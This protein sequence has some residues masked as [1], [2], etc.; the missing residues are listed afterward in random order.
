LQCH[1][2]I[3][4]DA[5][6]CG[7]C[8]ARV[9]DNPI[10]TAPGE[11]KAARPAGERRQLTVVFCD[12][13]GSTPLSQQFDPEDWRDIV[14]QY[15]Q[16]VRAA[17]ERFSG[18]VAQEL[19]DGLLAYFGWPAAREDDAERAIRA[20]L[21]MLDAIE[22]LNEKLALSDGTRLAVRVGMH[23]GPVVVG[24]GGQI[25]GET[26]NIAARVQSVAEPET[27]VVTSATQRLVPGMFVAEDRG[28]HELKGVR[29]PVVLFRIV[30]PSGVRS[31]LAIAA[32]RLTR[33]VGREL[34][35]ATLVDRWERA[36]DGEGQN[37]LIVGEAGVGKSRLAYELRERL[38]TTPHTWLECGATP[39]TD[40]T[41]FHPVIAL[42]TQGLALTPADTTAKKLEKIE[43]GLRDLATPE[44]VALLAD[45]L[46]LP[47][48]TP[49]GLNPDVQ[50][51][52]TMELLAQWSLAISTVQPLVLLVEDLH[53]CDASSLELLGRIIAQS[54]TA[55][56]LF[57]A[58]A[59]PE[60]TAP[61]PARSNLTMLQLARLTKR[62]AREMV[63]TLLVEAVS[64][65]TLETLVARADGVPLYVEELTKSVAEP[66]AARSAD[67]IPTT[68][69]G[70][71]MSRL[72]RLTTAKEVAQRA[73]VI[74]R[75]FDY[76]LL[77]AVAEMD[78]AG[79][80]HGLARLVDAEVVFQRGE[81]PDATYTFKHAL[82]QEAAYESL[83]KRTRQQLHGRVV[84]V[85]VS[86]FPELVDAAPDVVARHAESAGRVDAAITYLQRAGEQSQA[87]SAH[88]EAIGH[89]RHAI[90]LLT[91][92][93]ENEA[94][95]TREAVLQ[96]S[97]AG[98]LRPARGIAH[99][100]CGAAYERACVLCEAA[101]D[102]RRLGLA[103]GGLASFCSNGGNPERGRQLA[104]RVLTIAESSG[105][106]ELLLL[107]NLELGTA[108]HWHGR[109]AS[110]VPHLGAAHELYAA[111]RRSAIGSTIRGDTVAMPLSY[112]D[113]GVIALGLGGWALWTVGWPD[114]GLARAQ[115]A[116]ALA[117]ELQ[118]SF[119]VA[120]ALTV[121]AVVHS[122]RRD[123]TAQ[124]ERG[125]EAVVLSEAN[126]FPLF[127]G[128]GQVFY[129]SAR[130]LS[131]D[132]AAVEDV[133]AGLAV[134]GETGF[135]AGAP[136]MLFRLAE[137][138]MAG[139]QLADARAAVELALAVAAE[140]GQLHFDAELHRLQGEILLKAV[141]NREGGVGDTGVAEE[142][143]Q[144][145]LE[146]A[147]AQGARS[148][149]LR[150]A[151]SLARLWRD[152]G[153][154][155]A[156]RDLLA[157]IHAWFAEG[158]ETGDLI[159]AGALLREITVIAGHSA[160]R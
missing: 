18:H 119:N 88:E 125:H 102:T 19:G 152:Q 23:T 146:T 49:V 73:A 74:G 26:A 64:S 138:H 70:S 69:A 148:F 78:E 5:K 133:L 1:A 63:T 154:R 81:P 153:K 54:A 84:D 127:L 40:G 105:D 43:I 132:V 20:G 17:V 34:E 8:G 14:A 4:R 65:E 59:R 128:V 139:E 121:E 7:E 46:D 93:P 58:T 116:V 47:P 160:A 134:S 48:P 156:A 16:T 27:V 15:H 96:L 158:F 42:V 98:S 30:R 71:L 41:P 107:G 9:G 61:W 31:R 67:A 110:A 142:C 24:E 39:F 104:S 37:V 145:A 55:R 3:A 141:D 113:P 131:G 75:E 66:G 122:L 106:G 12:L 85:L 57:V 91:T 28:P 115:A 56:V 143:F 72:D 136:S 101:G 33:F 68:L 45:F 126:G 52:K 94:R 130:A 144:R 150:A 79:L 86:D 149:E 62:Q 103:L 76:P 83:L 118:D 140:T 35:L 13:V 99:P 114:R 25:F 112:L 155:V 60:F 10:T 11:P 137:A 117:R 108:E 44:H 100:D 157:P 95:Q 36:V 80:R 2:P 159:D 32:G 21:T 151:T 90:A 22:P 6:F 120:F 111:Q 89:L 51:R 123:L 147:R 53:W 109:Y 135:Q 87:R 29:D 129:G 38:A 77:A 124:A 82:V 92:C 97:L 50:R